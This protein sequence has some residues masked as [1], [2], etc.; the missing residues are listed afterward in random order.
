MLLV[1]GLACYSQGL[2]HLRPGPALA[3]GS[4]DFGVL[5]AIRHG[6]QRR[7]GR[8]AIGGTTERRRFFRRHASNCSC[9]NRRCQLWLLILILGGV[10]RGA[11]AGLAF[12]YASRRSDSNRRWAK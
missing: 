6:A 4:F 1:D 8:E 2:G 7:R 10:D 12:Y 11:F 9:L 5:Q 3:H